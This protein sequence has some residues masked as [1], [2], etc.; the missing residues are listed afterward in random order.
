MCSLIIA[1]VEKV[2][3]KASRLRVIDVTLIPHGV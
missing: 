3:V 1:A 2:A